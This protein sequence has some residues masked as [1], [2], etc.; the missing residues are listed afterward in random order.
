MGLGTN[1]YMRQILGF[2]NNKFSKPTASFYISYNCMADCHDYGLT[3]YDLLNGYKFSLGNAHTLADY[4]MSTMN[5]HTLHKAFFCS[6]SEFS[7]V[8]LLQLLF[9]IYCNTMLLIINVHKYCYD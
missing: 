8:I 9:A 5:T 2:F 4:P 3:R 1:R 7:L 6:E